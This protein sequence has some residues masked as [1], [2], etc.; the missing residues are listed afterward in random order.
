M[1]K[2]TLL[3][4]II[5]IVIPSQ[6]FAK[7]NVNVIVNGK[8][9]DHKIEFDKNDNILFPVRCLAEQFCYSVEW[10][11]SAKMATLHNYD[12][13]IVF[14]EN[15]HHMYINGVSFDMDL[16]AKIIDEHL[17]IPIENISKNIGLKT[18][19]NHSLN[20]LYIIE[21]SRV[22]YENEDMGFGFIIPEDCETNCYKILEK[23]N[24]KSIT[25]NFF[26]L[27]G[28]SLIFSLS[29]FDL[30]YWNN[31]VKNTFPIAYSEIFKNDSWILLCV[32]VSDLQ[33]DPNDAEQKEN[34]L[35]LLSSKQEV[36]DSIYIFK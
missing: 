25:I 14:R 23:H 22:L 32:N 10:N 2:I 28:K 7:E 33:Y 3:F 13:N 24:D 5:S 12:L 30:E 9:H 1:K 15:D 27:E 34:Y 4:F 16:P 18:I 8:A 6:V 17:F 31:E 26:D 19:Y 36:C 21:E 35:K 20:T 11:D 29:C